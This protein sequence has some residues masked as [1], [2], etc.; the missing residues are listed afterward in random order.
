[1]KVFTNQLITAKFVKNFKNQIGVRRVR[2]EAKLVYMYTWFISK[3]IRV[4]LK[5]VNF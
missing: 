4:P 2:L 5:F 1:M 3:N